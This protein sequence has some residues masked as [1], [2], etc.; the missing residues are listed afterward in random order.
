MQ[1][2][3]LS[4]RAD[5][6]VPAARD[7]LRPTL[8]CAQQLLEQG[9]GVVLQTRGGGP[10]SRGLVELARAFPGRIRVDVGFF[11]SEVKLIRDWESGCAP[12]GARLALPETLRSAGADVH[13]RVGPMIP[14]INDEPRPLRRLMRDLARCG[15]RSVIP[16]WLEEAPGLVRQIEHEVS[17]SRGRMVQGWF[18]MEGA[19]DGVGPRRIP[20]HVR[21]HGIQRLHA[22]AD[23]A[24]VSLTIC[25]CASAQGQGACLW[26]PPAAGEQ[27]QM[28]LFAESA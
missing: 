24:G 3:W 27:K 9:V 12:V 13:A 6:F 28:D 4:P 22:A 20:D 7:L 11:S 10:A 1:W 25:S 8:A 17:R 26:G 14:L 15:V 16:Y 23:Q 19:R 5:A 21:R 18:Q 2:V